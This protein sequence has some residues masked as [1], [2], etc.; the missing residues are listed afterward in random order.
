MMENYKQGLS[1]FNINS[2]TFPPQIWDYDQ[3][4]GPL[5]SSNLSLPSSEFPVELEFASPRQRS[6]IF[7]QTVSKP[8]K[9]AEDL[10]RRRLHISNIPFHYREMELLQLFSPFGEVE[11]VQIIYNDL[12]SQGY[13]FVTM[14]T[15]ESALWARNS[16]NNTRVGGRLVLVNPAWPKSKM[17]KQSE[18]VVRQCSCGGGGGGVSALD[19]LRA[20]TKLA[21]AQ[22]AVLSIK[23]QLMLSGKNNQDNTATAS[24]PLPHHL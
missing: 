14:Q 2:P 16:I 13:G 5:S 1:L 6:G 22:L 21:E 11:S 7:S 15:G 23:H 12:G 18:A 10:Y 20:E 9:E 4:F 19:L 17:S 8:E 24:A 3:P